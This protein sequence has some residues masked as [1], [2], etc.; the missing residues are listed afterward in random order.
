MYRSIYDLR[1]FY[2]SMHGQIVQR[3]LRRHIARWWPSVHG[4]RVLG[5]GYAVPYLDLFLTESERCIAV[6][7]AGQGAHHWPEDGLNLTVLS[8]ESELPIETNSI[9]RVILIH[10]LEN[11]ELLRANLQEI[12]RVLKGN[13]RVLVVVPNRVG[14][15]ARADWSPFGQG[16]PYSLSQLRWFM[17]DNLFSYERSQQVLYMLPFRWRWMMRFSHTLEKI[18]PYLFPAFCGVHMVEASKQL[19]AGVDASSGGAKVTV[20]GRGMFAQKQ[21]A[22]VRRGKHV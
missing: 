6:M 17:R 15:W 16:T 3:I 2:N 20:R 9:D 5:V 8:E 7:P 22:I 21:P 13:G 18:G 4:M 1:D 11:A 19:Y 10:S 14:F 12:W